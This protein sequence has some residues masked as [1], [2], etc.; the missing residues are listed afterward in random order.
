MRRVRG[1][2]RARARAQARRRTRARARAGPRQ[3]STRPRTAFPNRQL[4]GGGGGAA[5][6]A[7]LRRSAG[8]GRGAT[9]ARADADARARFGQLPGVLQRRG[10]PFRAGQLAS[11]PGAD[12]SPERQPASAVAGARRGPR[13]LPFLSR[14]GGSSW[15]V[16]REWQ[17]HRGPG[18]GSSRT[19]VP[20]V[21]GSARSRRVRLCGQYPLTSSS[22]VEPAR[23]SSRGGAPPQQRMHAATGSMPAQLVRPSGVLGVRRPLPMSPPC[24]PR[25]VCVETRRPICPFPSAF[26]LETGRRLARPEHH[27]P[28][29]RA[30]A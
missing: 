7:G 30:R 26:P 10:A 14:G 24:H 22:L 27:A 4:V 6:V 23:R 20:H 18:L 8:A 21:Q 16:S 29:P 11:R 19:A 5:S 2:P 3:A 17:H 9:R 28:P 13:A 12:P 1:R 25:L 15:P